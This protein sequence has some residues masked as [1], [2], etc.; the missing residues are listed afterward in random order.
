MPIPIAGSVAMFV[1]DA[2]VSPANKLH[3]QMQ[4]QLPC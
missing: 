4:M 3:V 2:A 1:L